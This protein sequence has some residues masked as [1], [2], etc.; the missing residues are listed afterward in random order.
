MLF[1]RIRWINIMTMGKCRS[2][3]KAKIIIYINKLNSFKNTQK[4]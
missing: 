2:Q 4:M 3:G 1:Q